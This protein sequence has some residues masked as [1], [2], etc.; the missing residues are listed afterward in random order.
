M[1]CRDLWANPSP[2]GRLDE[3]VG[4]P[5]LLNIRYGFL[6]GVEGPHNC[7]VTWPLARM[8]SGPKLLSDAHLF[9]IGLD[10]FY[11]GESASCF[12]I[13][14]LFFWIIRS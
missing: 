9:E 11:Q 8:W 3:I 4:R 2:R 10:H 7:V 5:Y 1:V 12:I 14:C 6:M 13:V